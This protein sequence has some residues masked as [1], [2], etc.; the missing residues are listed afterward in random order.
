M[1]EGYGLVLQAAS[2]G[3]GPLGGLFP[4]YALSWVAMGVLL[5]RGVPQA[6]ATS[7]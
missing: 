5:I 3:G 2:W 7:G 4:A 1:D 6:R